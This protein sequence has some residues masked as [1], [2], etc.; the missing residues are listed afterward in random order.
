MDMVILWLLLVLLLLD[1]VTAGLLLLYLD[2]HTHRHGKNPVQ[3]QP[4]ITAPRICYTTT[5]PPMCH[6]TSPSFLY[7]PSRPVT[8]ALI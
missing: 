6:A 5:P 4:L 2:M 7:T 3:G 8:T 1:R